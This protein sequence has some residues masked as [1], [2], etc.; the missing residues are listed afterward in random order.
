MFFCAE[1]TQ[2][3]RKDIP[4]I[5]MLKNGV[6]RTDAYSTLS[7]LRR[8]GGPEYRERGWG[9]VHNLGMAPCIHA[10]RYGFYDPR[11]VLRRFCVGLGLQTQR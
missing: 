5:V 2:S 4:V 6:S 1:T 8:N 9:D 10:L 7:Q 3:G 11:P